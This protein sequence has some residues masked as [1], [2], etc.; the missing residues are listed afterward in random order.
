MGTIGTGAEQSADTADWVRAAETK[1]RNA[2]MLI[3]RSEDQEP[4]GRAMLLKR[5]QAACQS[6]EI[7]LEAALMGME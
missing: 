5:A 3:R 2:L 6:A 4:Q 7:A 1:L